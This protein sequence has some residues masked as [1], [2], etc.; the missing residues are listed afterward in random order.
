MQFADAQTVP[1]LHRQVTWFYLTQKRSGKQSST[2]PTGVGLQRNVSS[3][4]YCENLKDRYR[5]AENAERCR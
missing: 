3:R 5:H 4:R 2:A 1:V